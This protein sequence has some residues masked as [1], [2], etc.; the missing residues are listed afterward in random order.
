MRSVVELSIY[1][2]IL[3]LNFGFR[4]FWVLDFEIRDVQS[5]LYLFILTLVV[6]MS[7]LGSWT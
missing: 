2:V 1:D 7:R 4:A 3:V 5:V 6:Q